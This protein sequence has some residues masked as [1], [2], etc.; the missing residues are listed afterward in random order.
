VS[1]ESELAQLKAEIKQLTVAVGR[2]GRD[3]H[4]VGGPGGQPLELRNAMQAHESHV[5]ST[6][7]PLAPTE[8]RL[9]DTPAVT[10]IPASRYL[11]VTNGSMDVE[12]AARHA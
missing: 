2:L 11:P 7:P 5:A 4:G 6:R 10:E 1:T 3:L 12:E 8:R 9:G